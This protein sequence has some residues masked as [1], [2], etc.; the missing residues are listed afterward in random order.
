MAGINYEDILRNIRVTFNLNSPQI[1]VQ[2][3]YQG[4]TY[5]FNSETD[6]QAAAKN[7]TA[8]TLQVEVV[9]EGMTVADNLARRGKQVANAKIDEGQTDKAA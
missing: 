4:K 1:K 7:R 3:V 5:K 6:F 8:L 2:I 9:E